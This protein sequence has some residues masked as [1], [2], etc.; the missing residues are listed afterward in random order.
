MA[1]QIAPYPFLRPVKD[2]LHLPPE[3]FPTQES[4]N[5]AG[6]AV[7]QVDDLATRLPSRPKHVAEP[8]RAL[9]ADHLPIP[10]LV[11]GPVVFVFHYVADAEWP[12][13]YAKRYVIA[14]P[15]RSDLLQCF[16]SLPVRQ[17]A[18]YA[19]GRSIQANTSS[20]VWGTVDF[21]S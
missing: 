17:V 3:A 9:G 14:I 13:S 4:H 15:N 16:Y 21:R 11:R 8:P 1:G 10:E 5:P 12:D 20:M 19:A 2:E 7:G 18:E 6:L